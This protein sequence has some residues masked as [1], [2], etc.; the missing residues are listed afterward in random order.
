[1]VGKSTRVAVGVPS[2]CSEGHIGRW[3]DISDAGVMSS[4]VPDG[5]ILPSLAS[6]RRSIMSD[7]REDQTVTQG[8]GTP[9]PGAASV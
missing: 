4:G 9:E 2:R 8:E 7:E 3:R 1:M 5:L 6:G